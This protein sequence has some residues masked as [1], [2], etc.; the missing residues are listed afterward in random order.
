MGREDMIEN[1]LTDVA[2]I[3]EDRYLLCE[4]EGKRDSLKVKAYHIRKTLKRE[5]IKISNYQ[6]EDKVY[7]KFSKKED[8]KIFKKEESGEMKEV[9][10]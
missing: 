3:G 8:I 7:L 2:T 6:V 9:R 5:D 4:N 10:E 1:L